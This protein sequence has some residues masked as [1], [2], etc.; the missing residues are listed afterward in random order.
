[1]CIRDRNLVKRGVAEFY[2][3]E[4]FRNPYE[5]IEAPKDTQAITLSDEQQIAF[6]HLKQQY[7]MEKG[8]V[9]LLY[10][11][12][13]SGKTLVFMKDV[14]KRQQYWQLPYSIL[15]KSLFLN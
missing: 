8:G 15:V 1:M 10:G 11:V 14:Y 4:I 12:T 5:A 2:D 7:E 6:Q 9:S 3:V 13:G